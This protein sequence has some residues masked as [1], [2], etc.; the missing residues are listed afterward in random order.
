MA[1]MLSVHQDILATLTAAFDTRGA[2][3][4][5]GKVPDGGDVPRIGPNAAVAPHAVFW[6]DEPDEHPDG[7]SIDGAVT[8]LGILAFNILCVAANNVQL[9]Q[10]RDLVNAA[11]VGHTLP[12]GSEISS[13][14]GLANQPV[15]NLAT[16][17]RFARVLGFY[18]SV[19]AT[20]SV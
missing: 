15:T 17:E 5:D 2:Y 3:L 12:G 20:V 16:P 13:N 10:L 18:A 7:R 8:A 6:M 9:T 14:G 11:L 4:F 19:G 1:E